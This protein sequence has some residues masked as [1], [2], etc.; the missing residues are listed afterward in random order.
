M[1]ILPAS[2]SNIFHT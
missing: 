1:G 2:S